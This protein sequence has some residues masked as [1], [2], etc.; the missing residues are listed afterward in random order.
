MLK[1]IYDQ[2][3]EPPTFATEHYHPKIELVKNVYNK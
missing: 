2:G 3:P 1:V